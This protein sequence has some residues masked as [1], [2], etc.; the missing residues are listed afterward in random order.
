MSARVTT[1]PGAESFSPSLERAGAR[2]CW[3][4]G[5]A[6]EESTVT[7]LRRGVIVRYLKL[8][9]S[10]HERGASDE[11]QVLQPWPLWLPVL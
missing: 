11:Q 7:P 6:E 9:R 4:K 5:W 3:F 10:G 1:W 8:V 2:D